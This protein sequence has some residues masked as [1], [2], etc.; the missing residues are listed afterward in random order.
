MKIYFAGFH[1]G[2]LK[3]KGKKEQERFKIVSNRL[4]SFYYKDHCEI[5]I[6]VLRQINRKENK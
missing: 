6:D 1:Y 3:D 4:V 2:D 5:V